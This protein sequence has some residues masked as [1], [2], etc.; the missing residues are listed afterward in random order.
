MGLGTYAFFV[1]VN[2]CAIAIIA[3]LIQR[4][5]APAPT[6]WKNFKIVYIT[7]AAVLAYVIGGDKLPDSYYDYLAT[8]FLAQLLY[9]IWGVFIGHC[10]VC[11]ILFS[12]WIR[13]VTTLKWI[14]A[15]VLSGT[16]ELVLLL[17][18]LRA[19]GTFE[20]TGNGLINGPFYREGIVQRAQ[21]IAN[22]RAGDLYSI[23]VG[24]ISYE[25]SDP[26]WFNTIERGENLTFAYHSGLLFDYAFSVDNIAL[27]ARAGIL[28]LIGLYLWVL[29]ATPIAKGIIFLVHKT[30]VIRT[31]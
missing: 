16:I 30:P 12:A 23:R 5:L 13:Q 18:L 28:F 25:V 21:E 24:G 4:A 11:G 14:A 26:S 10:L 31:T 27:T 8:S 19:A 7:L 29:T 3:A 17:L 1:L 9:G 20:R 2:G 15:F 22:T 6:P